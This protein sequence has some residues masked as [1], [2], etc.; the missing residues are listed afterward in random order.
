MFRTV[1]QKHIPQ[2]LANQIEQALLDQ[3]LKPGDRLQYERELQNIFQASRGAIREALGILKQKGLIEIKRGG[4]GGAYI[5][6]LKVSKVSESLT[7]LIKHRRVSFNELAEFR[8]CVE[9]LA[10]G[11]AAER[12]KPEEVAEMRL[13]LNEMKHQIDGG[14][15][16]WEKFY[17]SERKM[18]EI[19]AHLSGNLIIEWVL[20]TIHVNLDAYA[21]LVFWNEPGVDEAYRDWTEIVDGLEKGEV[22]RVN[23]LVR[24]HVFRFSQA[25]REGAQREGL[26]C[27][28]GGEILLGVRKSSDIE[29]DSLVDKA[30]RSDISESQT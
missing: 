1:R 27:G 29:R 26:I 14:R 11:L 18:H 13:L 5:T 16:V 15:T 20:T 7:F 12:V 19:L 21:E 25:I 10:A 9:G 6:D 24:S 28:E 2:E 8:E 30:K 17:Q 23:S 3:K 22:T 4:D